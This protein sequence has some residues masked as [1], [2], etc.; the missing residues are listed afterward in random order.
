M[1][2]ATSYAQHHALLSATIPTR[3]VDLMVLAAMFDLD[4]KFDTYATRYRLGKLQRARLWAAAQRM[5]PTSD[6]AN[7][8]IDVLHHAC[9]RHTFSALGLGERHA[10]TLHA[11]GRHVVCASMYAP[12]RGT[13]AEYLFALCTVASAL[14]DKTWR[15]AV[16]ASVPG[17]V[18]APNAWN[19][20]LAWRAQGR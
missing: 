1:E 13:N 5:R 4:D 9:D 12:Q 10:E 3:A 6:N 20:M 17:G 14:D 11:F 18:V 16:R 2:R 8:W 19:A 7:D 15:H